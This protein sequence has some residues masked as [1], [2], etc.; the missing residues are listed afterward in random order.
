MYPVCTSQRPPIRPHPTGA[1]LLDSF[2]RLYNGDTLE[3]IE[4]L[5]I[6]FIDAQWQ[7][8]LTTLGFANG[9]YEVQY[10]NDFL[11]RIT[12]RI[13]LTGMTGLALPKFSKGVV[14]ISHGPEQIPVFTV[15]ETPLLYDG[16]ESGDVS[17]W[18]GSAEGSTPPPN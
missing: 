2:G 11:A 10:W 15:L 18:D 14:A 7:P 1:V 3:L 16:F 8:R 6:F 13:P 17:Q 4:E 5:D 12:R 9:E